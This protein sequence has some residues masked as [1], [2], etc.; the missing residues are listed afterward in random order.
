MNYLVCFDCF[1]AM[2]YCIEDA[3]VD[4]TEQRYAECVS[5]W[6]QTLDVNEHVSYTGAENDIEFSA[7]RCECCNDTDAG[8]RYTYTN[9]QDE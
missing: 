8:R 7:A 9:G 1:V 6:A 4:M 5:A 2:E 3:L